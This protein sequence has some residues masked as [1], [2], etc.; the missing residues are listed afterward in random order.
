MFYNKPTPGIDLERPILATEPGTEQEIR[1]L[2][3]TGDSLD[4]PSWYAPNLSCQQFPYSIDVIPIG[5][6]DDQL[7]Y[8]PFH[9]DITE[10]NVQP[11]IVPGVRTIQQIRGLQ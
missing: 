3:L 2:V 1:S 9:A 7:P 5:G 11:D 8:Y 4:D 6:I 10:Y